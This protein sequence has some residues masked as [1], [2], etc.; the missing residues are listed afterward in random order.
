MFRIAGISVTAN[1]TWL[2]ALGYVVVILSGDYEA[3]LD[4][5]QQAQAYLWAVGVSFLFFGSIVLHE[6]GHAI[7]A[8]RNGI[9][10]LGIELWL[11]GGLAKMDRDPN[12]PGVEFRVAAAGPLVTALV[13]AACLGAA[14]AI[15]TDQ[16]G[17]LV[18]LQQQGGEEAWLASVVWLGVV[19]A[20][21]LVFN[22]IPAYPLDGGRIARSIA[23]RVS[24]DRDRATGIASWMGRVFG[25]GLVA[26]GVLMISTRPL[27][28]IIFAVMGWSLAQS[29]RGAALGRNLL[30]EA[31]DLTVT[32]V[33]D[34]QP[35]A[36]GDDV[37]VDRALEEFFWRYRWPW[38]PVVDVTGR[39]VGLIEQHAVERI[40]EAD[41]AQRRVGELIAPDSRRL[42]SVLDDTPLTAVLANSAI[43]EFGA[44]MAVD[45]QGMLRGVVTVEQAQRALRDAISRATQSRPD[46]GQ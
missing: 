24:G 15:D 3:M 6:F 46:A 4:P 13:A 41:R 36:I 17:R 22:L 26:L 5:G 32:D 39:F 28:G 16:A 1:W 8:R 45:G 20:F 11:L 19:N 29:A 38:F 31:R 7:V 35:V 25:Y 9:G 10:I 12:S 44:L 21:L 40:D 18:R 27:S 37:P 33:M 42:R 2:L 23:W 43:G 30:G 34:R 14:F